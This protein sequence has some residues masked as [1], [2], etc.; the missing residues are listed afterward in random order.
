[1]RNIHAISPAGRRME[2]A[3]ASAAAAMEFLRKA[4]VESVI[5]LK[6]GIQHRRTMARFAHFSD[7]RLQDLGF[8]RDWDGSIIPRR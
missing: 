1:M 7:H 6:T 2:V 4:L 3:S 5:D 8:E